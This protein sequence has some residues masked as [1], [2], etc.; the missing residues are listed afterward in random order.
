MVNSDQENNIL[1][2]SLR[3]DTDQAAAADKL[4]PG[5]AKELADF[6]NFIYLVH[7][8]LKKKR[9]DAS[10]SLKGPAVIGSRK[11]RNYIKCQ[12]F[13]LQRHIHRLERFDREVTRRVQQ[14]L[15]NSIGDM[16]LVPES[17]L[18][19][20]D[21][22]DGNPDAIQRAPSFDMERT[23]SSSLHSG[24]S[25]IA[26]GTSMTSSSATA[27]ESEGNAVE[28]LHA[29]LIKMKR[30]AKHILDVSNQYLGS[31]LE[32]TTDSNWG[33]DVDSRPMSPEEERHKRNSL[34]DMAS[35]KMTMESFVEHTKVLMKSYTNKHSK[36][37]RTM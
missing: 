20:D 11:A 15:G 22:V 13:M 24:D 4:R 27:A 8:E 32:T 3:L 33:G 5:F 14:V 23:S 7:N 10:A 37:R 28:Q 19:M 12:N 6:G 18:V 35:V 34:D 36:K 31:F 1:C 25:S 30:R 17:P 2:R 21:D 29:D 16:T 26:S 9:E